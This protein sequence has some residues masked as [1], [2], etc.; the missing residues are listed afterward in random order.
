MHM[1]VPT[2]CMTAAKL[3]REV[4]KYKTLAS[5]SINNNN[6][7]NYF[8]NNKNCIEHCMWL[9]T[10]HVIIIYIM[11]KIQDKVKPVNPINIT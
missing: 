11:I 5:Y 1:Y 8:H 4:L 6:Y 3:D 2:L 9:I 10:L 7:K